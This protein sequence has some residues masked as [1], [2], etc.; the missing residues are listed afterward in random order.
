M[1]FQVQLESIILIQF[2]S[3]N[4]AIFILGHNEVLTRGKTEASTTSLWERYEKLLVFNLFTL[5]N[6]CYSIFS[7]KSKKNR[8][9][10]KTPIMI[11]KVRAALCSARHPFAGRIDPSN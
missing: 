2:F 1:N 7:I 5:N 9:T 11:P 3:P 6:F 8:I 4:I 10:K